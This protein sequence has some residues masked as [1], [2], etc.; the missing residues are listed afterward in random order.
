[1]HLFAFLGISGASPGPR[2]FHMAGVL[3]GQAC[4]PYTDGQIC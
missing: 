1:L 3:M 4:D 2:K